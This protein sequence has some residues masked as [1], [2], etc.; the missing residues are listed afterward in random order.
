MTIDCFY[1]TNLPDIP[2]RLLL[3]QIYRYFGFCEVD[4]F[5][6]FG[7]GK[8]NMGSCKIFL[9]RK[10]AMK[11]GLFNLCPY[12]FMKLMIG[13]TN[14]VF[15]KRWVKC[16]NFKIDDMNDSCDDEK[17][18]EIDDIELEHELI[19]N[20]GSN[21]SIMP[22]RKN[23]I[24]KPNDMCQVLSIMPYRKSLRLSFDEQKLS[25][26][27]ANFKPRKI[28]TTIANLREF[29]VLNQ[30]TVMQISLLYGL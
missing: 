28:D 18:E 21:T 3:A 26:L 27:P 14:N 1:V 11:F 9:D 23:V 30:R 10:V 16:G 5:R 19:I 20:V 24:L 15:F 12:E 2:N 13:F 29:E 6:K 4:I 22:M 7:V 8:F 25:I 17:D